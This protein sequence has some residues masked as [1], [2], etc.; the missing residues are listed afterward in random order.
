MKCHKIDPFSCCSRSSEFLS[1]FFRNNHK[2]NNKRCNVISTSKRDCR[3]H[4]Q[5]VS[6][7]GEKNLLIFV[8]S[9]SKSSSTFI[10]FYDKI[11]FISRYI[12]N[13]KPP[14]RER[15]FIEVMIIIINY[16]THWC[17]VT[18]TKNVYTKRK[19]HAEFSCFFKSHKKFLFLSLFFVII[20][21]EKS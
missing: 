15:K 20:F 10:L 9:I 18:G 6:Y 17:V 12:F 5:N 21:M 16:S 19:T 4:L 2:N 13:G 7:M 14:K 1:S 8:P 3:E 11:F